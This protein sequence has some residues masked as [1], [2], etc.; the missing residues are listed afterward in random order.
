SRTVAQTLWPDEDP[1]GKRIS[2]EDEPRAGDWL[3]VVGVVDDLKQKNLAESSDPAIYQPYLQVS[4]P[5]FLAH[6][7]FAVKTTAAPESIA[8]GIRAVLKSV[9]REQPVTIASMDSLVS[10]TTAEPRF[11]LRLLAAFALI[12]LLLT[13]VGVYGVLSYSV[14]Q[15]TQEIGVRMAL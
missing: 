4:R 13:V 10:T 1:L 14:A 7:T 12:A 3:T 6:M 15:R 2:M 8:P 9:D 11:Q 5:F